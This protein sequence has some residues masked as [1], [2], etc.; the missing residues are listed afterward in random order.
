MF[1]LNNMYDIQNVVKSSRILK[2]YLKL[3]FLF[4]CR[5]IV[6][7][8][9]TALLMYISLYSFQSCYQLGGLY[10]PVSIDIFRKIIRRMY[11]SLY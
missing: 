2:N 11:L 1:R 5:L 10:F 9:I 4:C 8:H 6:I 7:S 3:L